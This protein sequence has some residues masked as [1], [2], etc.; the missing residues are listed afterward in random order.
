M[1]VQLVMYR[2]KRGTL[3]NLREILAQLK[4]VYLNSGCLR[5]EVYRDGKNPE[6]IVELAHFESEAALL[7]FESQA[8]P[9][10]SEIFSRFCNALSLSP[11]DVSV[12]NLY[13]EEV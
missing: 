6:L 10:R 8:S 5:Y 13:S 4:V 7:A 9:E 2:S 1:I 11:E 12:S 3:P